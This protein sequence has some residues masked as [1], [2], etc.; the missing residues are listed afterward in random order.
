MLEKLGWWLAYSWPLDD[1]LASL[2]FL[3]QTVHIPGTVFVLLASSD[4]DA[5]SL[6]TGFF[7]VLL[8]SNLCQNVNSSERLSRITTYKTVF[9]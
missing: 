4:W 6:D 8:P 2:I 7:T 1:F 5:V 3:K 9:S